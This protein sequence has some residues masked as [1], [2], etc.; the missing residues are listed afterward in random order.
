MSVR[1]KDCLKLPALRDAKVIAGEKGLNRSVTAITVIELADTSMLTN[2]LLVG[3]ELLLSALVSIKEDIEMQCRL[4]RHLHSVG[5]AALVIY[6]V[7]VFVPKIDPKLIETADEVGFPLIIMPYGKLNFRYSDVISE[8]MELVII[9]RKQEK[10]YVP[11]MVDRISQLAPQ[12]RSM[13]S[14]LRLLSDHLHCTLLLADRF[15]E[16][17]AAAAWPVSNEW[18]F[19]L[20]L[21][22]IQASRFLTQQ[23]LE[24]TFAGKA[25]IVWNLPVRAKRRHDVH[26]I[27]LDEQGTQTHENL[28]QAVEVVELFLNIWSQ[29]ANYE[30]TD[31][32]V[33]AIF[34]DQPAEKNQITAKMNLNIS[35]IHTVWILRL[36]K[37]REMA[38][39]NQQVDCMIKLKKYL[40]EHHKLVIVDFYEDYLVALCDDAVFDET[41][42]SL[43]EE[44]AKELEKEFIQMEGV[45]AQNMENTT[46]VRE[47]YLLTEKNLKLAR[48]IFPEKKVFT[49]GEMRFVQTCGDLYAQG[50]EMLRRKTACL[51]PLRALSDQE[52]LLQ[53]LCAYLLDTNANTQNTGLQMHL[54]KNTVKYRLNKIRATLHCDLTQM[55]ESFEV[56]QAVALY[57]LSLHS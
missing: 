27:V 50:E 18:N 46:Q 33:R 14:V 15:F 26:L 4:V 12:N 19:Q 40:Q 20:V 5:E 54:H 10:Y 17:K 43:A 29:D 38:E 31:A 25:A 45:I 52:E 49:T 47:V 24:M 36:T 9:D 51:N 37:N 30:H 56:Y 6:Y 44:F 34:N 42:L 2:D 3:N 55:P 35:S 21:D 53:T 57:R 22:A 1:V 48:I 8:V 28:R 23:A 11:E 32:L 13:N 16:T 41:E 7:G 39:K